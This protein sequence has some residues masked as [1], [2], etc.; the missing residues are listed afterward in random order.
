VYKKSQIEVLFA[1]IIDI[2]IFS[3]PSVK[4]RTAHPKQDTSKS[5]EPISDSAV[6]LPSNQQTLTLWEEAAGVFH[7]TWSYESRHH[8]DRRLPAMRES[9]RSTPLNRTRP[10]VRE[11]MICLA[12]CS[13]DDLI[14]GA[15][16]QHWKVD[17]GFERTTAD[18]INCRCVHWMAPL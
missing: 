16:W 11:T 18:Q 10:L 5:H 12:Q 17:Y 7:F 4:W 3:S 14:P 9:S 8:S 2:W 13:G 1:I 6:V 15:A